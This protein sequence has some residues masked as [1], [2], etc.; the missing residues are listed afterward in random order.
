MSRCFL[1]RS[2][3]LGKRAWKSCSTVA[4]SCVSFSYLVRGVLFLLVGPIRPFTRLQVSALAGLAM[5]V[6]LCW[7]EL[8]CPPPPP[9]LLPS[10]GEVVAGIH[11]LFTD[12]FRP[13]W[14]SFLFFYFL[15]YL[16]I[17]SSVYSSFTLCSLTQS[18]SYS[19]KPKKK[20]SSMTK[21]N[22]SFL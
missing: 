9:S 1:I 17:W 13:A 10:P 5:A 18:H 15:L 22:N 11:S 20:R 19:P 4:Y 14:G 7:D 6:C 12:S 16:F 2:V 3:G 21:V 8:V